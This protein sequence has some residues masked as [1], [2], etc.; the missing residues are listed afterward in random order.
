MF[1]SFESIAEMSS[2]LISDLK[3]CVKQYRDLDNQIRELNKTLY[4]K[5][6]SRKCL[7]LELTD[8][9]KLPNFNGIDN[10]KI[11]DDGSTIKIQRPGTHNKSWSLSKKELEVLVSAYFQSS[12]HPTASGCVEYIVEKRK[13]DLV[14]FDFGFTRVIPEE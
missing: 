10:L 1:Q 8:L 5:R 7:E 2:E 4:D 6:E 9:V 13:K 14:S 11:D 3:R 12:S